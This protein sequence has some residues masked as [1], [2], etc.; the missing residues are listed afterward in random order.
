M[1]IVFPILRAA[2]RH[3]LGLLGA[4]AITGLAGP[5]PVAAQHQPLPAFDSFCDDN[6]AWAAIGAFFSIVPKSNCTR[7]DDVNSWSYLGKSWEK[8][9]PPDGRAGLLTRSD[10]DYCLLRAADGVERDHSDTYSFFGRFGVAQTIHI[11]EYDPAP[12]QRHIKGYRDFDIYIFGLKAPLNRQ[13]FEVWFPRVDYPIRM[14]VDIPVLNRETI[15]D[16]GIAGIDLTR[17]A[18]RPGE[19]TV[20]GYSAF[21]L[22]RALDGKKQTE[23]TIPIIGKLISLTLVNGEFQHQRTGPEEMWDWVQYASPLDV[24]LEKSTPAPLGQYNSTAFPEPWVGKWQLGIPYAHLDYTQTRSGKGVRQA[25]E[26]QNGENFRA[27]GKFDSG[28]VVSLVTGGTSPDWIDDLLALLQVEISSGLDF[29]PASSLS[30]ENYLRPPPVPLQNPDMPS[31]S[32]G[33]TTIEYTNLDAR[34]GYEIAAELTIKLTLNLL[35]FSPSW[36]WNLVDVALLE[37]ET[38]GAIANSMGEVHRKDQ[39]NGTAFDYRQI[40]LINQGTY[41]YGNDARQWINDCL[42]QPAATTPEEPLE[43]PVLTS[44]VPTSPVACLVD[45]KCEGGEPY[46]KVCICDD[47]RGTNPRGCRDSSLLDDRQMAGLIDTLSRSGPVCSD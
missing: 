15:G 19:I 2:R 21:L 47:A 40:G 33:D 41:H 37:E 11:N 42:S 14:P 26:W 29:R 20:N 44:D 38:A 3:V 18:L 23:L 6:G 36:T 25:V 46:F 32:V 7:S 9:L 5:S 43:R 16:R 34:A 28:G 39:S 27:A 35:F 1:L 31:I 22:A 4:L 17:P 10:I 13:R 12:G 45:A 24:L 8:L 30:L